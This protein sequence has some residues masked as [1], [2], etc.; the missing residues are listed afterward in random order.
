[1]NSWYGF[2]S[3]ALKLND[4]VLHLSH[5]HQWLTRPEVEYSTALLVL[6]LLTSDLVQRT[7]LLARMILMSIVSSS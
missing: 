6:T 2:V 7:V 1:M 4:L 5:V 3:V